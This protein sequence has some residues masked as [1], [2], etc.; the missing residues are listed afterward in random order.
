MKLP[1]ATTK[2]WELL[3]KEKNIRI[4][5]VFKILYTKNIFFA[6]TL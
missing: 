1:Y 5:I 4:I 3:K 2:F 6:I